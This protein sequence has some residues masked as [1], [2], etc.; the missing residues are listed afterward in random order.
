M[1][2]GRLAALALAAGM[3]SLSG[4]TYLCNH[5]WFGKG[6]ACC[7]PQG[8]CCGSE[9]SGGCPGSCS[10]GCEGGPMLDSYAPMMNSPGIPQGAIM[11]PPPPPQATTMPPLSAP[12]RLVPQPQSQPIPYS[13]P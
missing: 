1:F 6:N 8:T 13:P 7:Q 2:R 5:P 12:P 11:A 3:G 10:P 4:C 9:C